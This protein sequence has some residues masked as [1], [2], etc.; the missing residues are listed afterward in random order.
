MNELSQELRNKIARA[1]WEAE[2]DPRHSL[3]SIGMGYDLKY[4]LMSDPYAELRPDL[5]RREIRYLY[6]GIPV[7]L[8]PTMPPNEI[9][10]IASDG[11]TMR[12][13]NIGE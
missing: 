1:L 13:V 8:D 4:R 9:K 3:A 7:L 5:M 6:R 2:R 11:S 12:I 10:L